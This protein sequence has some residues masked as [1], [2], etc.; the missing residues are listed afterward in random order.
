[1]LLDVLCPAMCAE[2]SIKA[3]QRPCSR[4]V[5]LQNCTDLTSSVYVQIHRGVL[6]EAGSE[7]TGYAPGT[8]VAVKVQFLLLLLLL[9]GFIASC[10]SCIT[11]L[12][13]LPLSCIPD[14]CMQP[15]MSVISTVMLQLLACQGI[16]MPCCTAPVEQSGACIPI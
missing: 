8:M 4:Q 7:G 15:H 2:V 5:L 13:S 1:M 10:A 9:L 3:M 12:T 14:T 6:S 16:C 11:L